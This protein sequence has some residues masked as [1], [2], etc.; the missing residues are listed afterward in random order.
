M[1]EAKAIIETLGLDPEKIKT[2]DDFKANVDSTFT[3]NTLINE[4]SE[5]VKKILGQVFSTLSTEIKKVAKTNEIELDF[6]SPELKDKKVKDRLVYFVDQLSNKHKGI[7]D[8]L[9]IKA[10]T[11]NDDKIKDLQGKYDKEVQKSKDLK[12]LL[13]QTTEQFNG[14][15]EQASTQIKGVKLDVHK[16]D[17]FG[18]L[19][20]KS[21]ISDI[22]RRGFNATIDEK[23]V[24]D[25]DETEKPIIKNKKGEMIPSTKVTGAFKSVD[26]VLQEEAIVAK[27]FALNPNSG[28]QK[29]APINLGG[30]QAAPAPQQGQRKVA[31]RLR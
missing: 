18:K 28:Q 30:Q 14:F 4:E 23:Y 19:K 3:R 29:P 15:K 27:V 11:G 31:E 9:T 1:L 7:V 20:F 13:D 24:F 8:D 5:P 25:L 12:G 16:R 21:D 2:I 10:N 26:E 22:E 17:A 6:A